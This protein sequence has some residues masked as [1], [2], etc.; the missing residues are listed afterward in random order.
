M[1]I[2]VCVDAIFAGQDFIESMEAVSSIGIEAY[3]FWA[4]WDKDINALIKAQNEYGLTPAACCTRF[5]SLVDEAL[6]RDYIKGLEASIQAAKKLGCK[7]LISQ[8]G[9]DLGHSRYSQRKSLIAGLKTCVPLLEAEDIRLVFEPLNTFVD[10]AGYFLTRSDEAFEIADAVG[11]PN[12]KVLFDI[13]HQQ[14]ME[15]NLINRI[16]ENIELIGHFHAAGNPGR[17]ELYTGEINYPEVFRAIDVTGY[18]G[19]VGFEYFPLDE[20]LQ[21]IRAFM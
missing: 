8:V 13:Y 6:R 7:T 9:D 10:H 3:E 18:S 5:I 4:W 20:P 11:S 12:V 21:G 19:F 17:H 14:I 1:K 15:G 16:T 2:S